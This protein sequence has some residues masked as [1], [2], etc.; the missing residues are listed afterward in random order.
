MAKPIYCL[1]FLL[2]TVYAFPTLA[3]ADPGCAVGSF[4]KNKS[5]EVLAV[6]PDNPEQNIGETGN[7]R[8]DTAGDSE[9][10]VK[11]KY[12]TPKTADQLR[13]A[14]ALANGRFLEN[15]ANML[16]EVKWPNGLLVRADSCG[17]VN[18]FYQPLTHTVELCYEFFGLAID[19][20]PIQM[21][22]SDG[23]YWFGHRPSQQEIQELSVGL[24]TFGTLHEVGHAMINEFQ[25]AS[26]GRE[27]DIADQIA[28]YFMVK[29]NLSVDQFRG[30]LWFN[31][32]A[33]IFFSRNDTHTWG[34]QRQ[35]NIACWAFGSN[36]KKYINLIK[37]GGVS[38]DRAMQCPNEF[39]KLNQAVKEL[40]AKHLR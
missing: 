16:S 3:N 10:N 32:G 23:L 5:C 40:L 27:E 7:L 29:S 33:R 13:I 4:Q 30:P 35:V 38:S 20:A 8:S 1:V 31:K 15:V 26:F 21:R 37:L 11:V 12:G 18:M 2:F 24:I 14:Q 22:T 25:I 39:A 9:H 19:N 17:Q 6:R 28:V 34:P 36:P